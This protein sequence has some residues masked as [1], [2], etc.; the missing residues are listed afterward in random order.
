MQNYYWR[1]VFR[2]FKL[3]SVTLVAHSTLMVRVIIIAR[4]IAIVISRRRRRHFG[5]YRE[6]FRSI[7]SLRQISAI[8]AL[9]YNYVVSIQYYYHILLSNPFIHCHI[10]IVSSDSRVSNSHK[11]A[12]S[13]VTRL[14]RIY[15]SNSLASS[16][17]KSIEVTT[18]R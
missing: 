11:A 15:R 13:A 18:D 4:V 17:L 9:S 14:H 16:D 3:H 7:L 12:T 2:E 6:L 10:I 1:S 5:P 8:Y